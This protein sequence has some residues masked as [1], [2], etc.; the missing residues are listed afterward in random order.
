MKKNLLLLLV[1]IFAGL[2][3]VQAQDYLYRRNDDG[4]TASGQPNSA[5]LQAGTNRY[6]E[7]YTIRAPGTTVC[8]AAATG[9]TAVTIIPAVALT[10]HY[11][12]SI[13]CHNNTTVASIL[14]FN[15]NVTAFDSDII[16]T[17]TL[18]TN[19]IDLNYVSPIKIAANAVLSFT[20]TTTATSTICCANYKDYPNP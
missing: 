12:N 16:G 4:T 6:R 14:T 20:P 19:R 10:S 7:A 3:T 11:V 18:G 8:S 13:H 2:S 15:N 9:T 1:L 5:P 17:T